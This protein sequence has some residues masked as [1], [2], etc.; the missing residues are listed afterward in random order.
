M[1]NCCISRTSRI[2]WM[3]TLSN[4]DNNSN[5]I[6]MMVI[7]ISN[8]LV[9]IFIET[10]THKPLQYIDGVKMSMEYM[11][12]FR[13][14]PFLHFL[15]SSNSHFL[16]L[17]VQVVYAPCLCISELFCRI[18]RHWTWIIGFLSCLQDFCLTKGTSPFSLWLTS[19]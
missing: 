14:R 10:H 18:G 19:I 6:C 8:C 17:L 9:D 12:C 1:C 4:N 16:W 13:T 5:S 11:N 7:G 3:T 15:S 2:Q